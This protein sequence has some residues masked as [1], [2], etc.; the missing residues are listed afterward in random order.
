VTKRRT[1]HQQEE[2]RPPRWRSSCSDAGSG[3]FEPRFALEDI[4]VSWSG[5]QD[6]KEI[7]FDPHVRKGDP[8]RTEV[9][10]GVWIY[11]LLFLFVLCGSHKIMAAVP[12]YTQHCSY[13]G[14]DSLFLTWRSKFFW[15][16]LTWWRASRARWCGPNVDVRLPRCENALCPVCHGDCELQFRNLKLTASLLDWNPFLLPFITPD[17]I[18][19]DA[20]CKNKSCISMR[21]L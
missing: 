4:D 10:E 15:A 5:K 8:E 6:R 19:F 7:F 14:F 1:S 11:F 20:N 21:I 2:A 18:N 13:L 9:E 16:S 17:P 3:E 12:I